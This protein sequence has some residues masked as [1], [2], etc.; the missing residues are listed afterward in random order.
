MTHSKSS[1]FLTQAIAIVFL[2]FYTISIASNSNHR[3]L[4]TGNHNLLLLQDAYDGLCINDSGT[5]ERCSIDTLWF[6]SGKPGNYQLHY[7]H[8][9]DTS[10]TTASTDLCLSSTICS[11]NNNNKSNSSNSTELQMNPC[12]YCGTKNWDIVGDSDRGYAITYDS[13]KYCL[14]RVNDNAVIDDCDKGHSTYT[15]KYVSKDNLATMM[16]DGARLIKAVNSHDLVLVKQY[17]EE[18]DVDVNAREWDG[19]TPLLAA[20]ERGYA[21]IVEYLI[22]KDADID[23]CD[24]NSITPLIEAAIGGYDEIVKIL[25]DNNANVSATAATGVTALWLASSVGH[26]S[27]VQYL[28]EHQSDP[29][30]KKSDGQT[31]LHVACAGGFDN[32]VQLLVYANALIDEADVENITPLI[33]AA[34]NGSAI[35]VDLLIKKNAQ[36]NTMST[37]GYTPLIV[38]CAHGH[39]KVVQLL[40]DAGAEI[41][42]E[43]PDS[44]TGLMYAAA[45]GYPDIVEYLIGKGAKIDQRHSQGGSALLEAASS[46]NV[47]CVNLLLSAGADPLVRDDDNV[48]ALISAASQGHADVVKI[49][50]SYDKNYN[51]VAVS[52]GTPVIYAAGGGFVDTVRLLVNEAKVDVNVIVR[53]TP[54][55]LQKVLKARAEGTEEKNALHKDGVTALHLAVDGGYFDIVKIL[56]EDGNADVNIFDDVEENALSYAMK[57]KYYDV[58]AYLLNH[59][60]DPNISHYLDDTGKE[61]NILMDAI[62]ED[63]TQL[64]LLLMEKGVSLDYIDSDGVTF[65][66]L[67]A[68]KGLYEV[69]E[70]LVRHT[71]DA[72]IAQEENINPLIASASEGHYKIVQLLLEKNVF[73]ANIIDSDGSNSL[74]TAAVRGHTD[75]VKL[76]LANHIDVNA[77]NIDGHTALMFA[78]NAKN[79]LETLSNK[80][81]DYISSNT[82]IVD[83]SLSL[84]KNAVQTQYNIIQMLIKHGADTT[85]KDNL[86]NLAVDLDY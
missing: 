18:K 39:L 30:V 58:A 7:K 71:L 60:A 42:I 28:L 86:G 14:S 41:D 49:L 35:I 25:V 64:A 83:G 32:V 59:N 84:V 8:N 68:Y 46:G 11:S 61:H 50:L 70:V 79:Q 3:S 38:S 12:S 67:A 5:F 45:G 1:F 62:M 47:T 31:S 10:S 6:L 24:K 34:E 17:I 4:R 53:A 13:V 29:N 56:V 78:Y 43:Q 72:G 15:I 57:K 74:M 22:G 65:R 19:R 40:V 9:H 52:G 33:M 54:A 27:T 51:G 2:S 81:S 37:T 80:Y 63:N 66:A 82:T 77:R 69:M 44:V 85:I 16:S 21:D 20:S 76:L 26:A 73:H 23:M 75:V 36:V 55:F 48:T